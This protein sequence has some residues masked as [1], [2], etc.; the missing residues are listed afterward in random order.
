LEREILNRISAGLQTLVSYCTLTL[1]LVLFSCNRQP[2]PVSSI[3]TNDRLTK[4]E[5]SSKEKY[6]P[7]IIIPINAN[8][9]PVPIKPGKPIVRI[10][11][12]G[13]GIPFFTNYGTDQ[14][15]P[16][17]NIICSAVDKIGNL[18]LGTGGAGVIRYD[19]KRF[20]N[21]TKA[22]G[23][24]GNV[25]F[26]ILEDRDNN[27][28]FGTT[29]G[30]S[31]YDG[32][33]FKT[34]TTLDGLAGDFVTCILQDEQGILWFGTHDGGVSKYDGR[35][36]QNYT[37]AQ[38]LAGNYV[39]C[40]V[41]DAHENLWIGTD[42]AGVSKYDRRG[43]TTYNMGQGLP[44]NSVNCITLDR[45]GNLWLGTNAGL[46]KY[47]FN[48][49]KNY[50]TKDGLA[51]NDIY[52]SL[53]DQAGNLWF[54]THTR[55]V[56]QYDGTKFRNYGVSQGLPGNTISSVVSDKGGGVWITS[57]GGGISKYEGNGFTHYTTN[58]GL[59]ANLVFCM[60]QDHSG[61]LWFGTYEGGVSKY[62]GKHFLNYSKAQGLPD[63]SI[64]S[65]LTDRIGNV[66][67]GSDRA[68]VTEYD[69][70]RFINYTKLQGLAGNSVISMMEDKEGNL[71]FGTR[72]SGVSKFDGK[73]FTNYTTAQGLAGNN[74]WSIAQDRSGDIWFG[75]QE[76]G[77]SKFDGHRFFNYSI[78]S[79]LAG[80][81]IT[82]IHEDKY[83]SLWFATDGEGVSKFDGKSFRNYN[84][85]QGLANNSVTFISED[86]SRHLLWFGTNSGLSVVHLG[87]SKS[88]K[89]TGVS[90]E[91]FTRSTGFPMRDVSTAGMF[92]DRSGILW[93][94]SG[95]GKLVRFD[96]SAVRKQTAPLDLKIQAVKVHNETV[97]WNHLPGIRGKAGV[98]D[99]LS[100][101]NEMFTSFGKLLAPSALAAM[102]KKY[103]NIKFDSVRRYYPVPENLVLPYDDNDVTIDFA[104]IAPG[105]NN[106]VLYQYKLE[107]YNDAWSPL[108]NTSTAAFG[109]IDAGHYTLHIR[110]LS[111][112][113]I[114]SQLTYGIRVLRPW[115]GT[116][117]AYAL[118]TI[119]G[120][121][122]LYGIY[123][124]RIRQIEKE[125]TLQLTTI[126][127]AQE[128]ERK[129]IS[130]DLHDGVGVKLS[131]LKLFLSSLDEET[132]KTSDGEMKAHGQHA[133][134]LINEVIQDV[135]QVLVN[136]SPMV[137]EE[138][139]YVV[140]VEALVN[141]INQSKQLHVE[142][143]VFGM[144]ERLKKDY[145]LALY[146]ITQE[147]LNNVLKHAAAKQVLLQL[148]Q[149]NRKIILMIEDDGEGFEVNAHKDGYGLR[150]LEARTRL[151]GGILTVD[152]TP[153][154]GTSISIEIP[155][156]PN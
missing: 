45:S 103:S 16:L 124:R 93:A 152:S 8:N 94:G 27:T 119:I 144:T 60:T 137:L 104:A 82:C 44:G 55:G 12:S 116:W 76:N 89:K 101:V 37:V 90:F 77:A 126:V 52:C 132:T 33:S 66:W 70:S 140:A 2:P 111:P 56:S 85:D 54:G 63:I 7:P 26:C 13:V 156:H 138:F 123:R 110:A 113:G 128:D 78:A 125:K 143:A 135:R 71:W 38:G 1:S 151:I 36:F 62:D 32:K 121:G 48:E 136:L 50:T 25:V 42:A 88:S 59:A 122:L 5:V 20:T 147:L 83:G 46:S 17:N 6:A 87:T 153:G 99:S 81:N 79:G 84:T 21:Y 146:R 141:T 18:W 72:G 73:Q 4:F 129:R 112:T 86:E 150:N 114:Q 51:D 67:F 115:W 47:D 145:E 127:I 107:G 64:W 49:F 28:W 15:L 29:A 43:F 14:G 133:E 117:W 65:L 34:Y 97:C 23:F 120:A 75:T 154:K 130:R 139:G 10:D 57:H 68:G 109:N 30:L 106:Q 148:G 91:N 142:L 100:V 69:G 134:E 74:V 11:S 105:Q 22:Q 96:Y 40:M 98:V 9:A 61:N 131:A 31:K 102:D 24:A 58:Q 118:Y 95:E 19:G 53:Q 92:V 41:E 155:Y 80:N 149:R 35:T 3:H 39:R 108:T